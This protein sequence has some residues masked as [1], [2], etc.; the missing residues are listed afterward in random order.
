M[1][2]DDARDLK[3][4]EKTGAISSHLLVEDSILYLTVG[5]GRLALRVA[6]SSAQYQ[7]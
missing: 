1:K 7:L 3:V 6:S 4:T 5:K 2:R